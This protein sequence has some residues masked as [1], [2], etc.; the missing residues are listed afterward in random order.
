LSVVASF[1]WLPT[2]RFDD[3]FSEIAIRDDWGLKLNGNFIAFVNFD[4]NDLVGMSISYYFGS[5]GFIIEF[6]LNKGK[7]ISLPF[8]NENDCSG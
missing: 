4:F 1:G 7:I 6:Y 2:I 5:T 8:F 3:S